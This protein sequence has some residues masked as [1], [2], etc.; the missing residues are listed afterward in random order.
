MYNVLSFAVTI[1]VEASSDKSP[2]VIGRNCIL[3]CNYNV[4]GIS[5]DNVTVQKYTWY[6]GAG[7]EIKSN[8]NNNPNLTLTKLNIND[9]MNYY[10]DI[11]LYIPVLDRNVSYTS[12]N[13]LLK[14]LGIIT[15]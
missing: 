10:C 2:K 12:D 15:N 1:T 13:Y 4:I 6:K 11:Y 9:S 14:F 8:D 3:T 5:P 7:E